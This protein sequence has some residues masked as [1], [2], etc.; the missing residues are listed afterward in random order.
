MR[1][2]F[3]GQVSKPRHQPG[4][5]AQGVTLGNWEFISQTNNN[6]DCV[7][8]EDRF[9]YIDDLS[10]LEIINLLNIGM[11]SYN[12]KYHIPSDIPLHGQYVAHENLLSQQY[13]NK[14]NEWTIKQKMQIS[15]KKT[16]S[17]IINFT[18]NYQF[19]TRLILNHTNIEVVD[20]VKILGTIITDKLTW[21]ENC[22]EIIKKVNKRML[23]LKKILSFGATR[24]EMVHI[25]IVYCRSLLE[26][27][28]VVWSSSLTQ[29]NID[30]LER[31]QKSFVKLILGNQFKS[32]Y[33]G[34]YE[35]AL[36]KLNLQSLEERRE[37]LCLK[38]AKNCIKNNKLTDLFPE[39]ENQHCLRNPEKYNVLHANTERLKNSSIIYMQNLLNIDARNLK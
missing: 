29:E 21:D 20:K 16:K 17:M 37:E 34:S 10:I 8:I 1:V 13:L 31:T 27:S 22:D 2:K 32:D 38:F 33:E 39:N 12:I 14:I 30:D 19:M 28:A 35:N 18:K 23:L 36:M 24:E 4:S 11:T 6:A 26:Q 3:H 25:W 15:E 9:K 5:G 7:P